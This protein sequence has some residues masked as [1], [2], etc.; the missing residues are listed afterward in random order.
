MAYGDSKHLKALR[1]GQERRKLVWMV[2]AYLESTDPDLFNALMREAL[3]KPNE[4]LTKM[5]F[6]ARGIQSRNKTQTNTTLRG[7][8]AAA[9]NIQQDN[10][11]AQ[12]AL[13][14]IRGQ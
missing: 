12:A 1:D 5:L 14:K 11:D 6:Q 13:D 4:V 2:G 3:A 7:I 9:G 8:R 10:A